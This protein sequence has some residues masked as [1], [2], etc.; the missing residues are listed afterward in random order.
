MLIRPLLRTSKRLL[1]SAP[2][3]S[4]A[5]TELLAILDSRSSPAPKSS[6]DPT[7]TTG[8]F[9]HSRLR[10]PADFPAVARWTGQ[11][12]AGIVEGICRDFDT[13]YTP[14]TANHAP[15]FQEQTRDPLLASLDIRQQLFTIVARLDKVSDL[16]CGVIDLA[17]LVKNVHP[18]QEW[19]EASEVAH[20]ELHNYMNVLNTHVGLHRALKR[21]I[22]SIPFPSSDTAD[23]ELF[24]TY[25]VA[26]QF[27]RDF[28]KS[29]IHLPPHQR[30]LFVQ[31]SDTISFLGQDIME[32]PYR[33]RS[34]QVEL[35]LGNGGKKMRLRRDGSQIHGL[36]YGDDERVRKAA[37][38]AVHKAEPEDL[39]T[40]EEML[41]KRCEVARLV[42]YENWAELTL[43]DKMA[44]TPVNVSS[45]LDAISTSILPQAKSELSILQRLKQS[46]QHLSSPP[47]VY[48]WDRD[49]LT[50]LFL[51]AT[52]SPKD[53]NIEEELSAYLS[54]GTVFR[55]LSHLFQS[56][57]GLRFELQSPLLGETWDPSVLKLSMLDDKDEKVGTV[58]LDLFWREGKNSAPAHYTVTCSRRTDLDLSSGSAVEAED[59]GGLNVEHVKKKGEEGTYQLPVVVLVCGFGRS[60]REGKNVV[61]L[62]WGEVETLF[63]EMGHAIHSMIGQTPYHNSSGTRVATDFVELPSIL[64]EHFLSSPLILSLFTHFSNQSPLPLPKLQTY[65]KQHR[66]FPALEDTWQITLADLDL[67]YHSSLPLSPSFDSTSTFSRVQNSR[68]PI[69]H[70]AGTHHQTQFSHLVGYG[71]TYYSYIFDRAIASRLFHKIFDNSP[72]DRESG[73]WFKEKLLRWGSARDPWK[74]VADALGP[75]EEAERVRSGDEKAMEEVGRWGVELAKANSVQR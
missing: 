46:T 71:A 64:M 49:Y 37:Y 25:T 6:I 38:L 39:E 29:G 50:N 62:K 44:K 67:E 21:I 12:V 3:F 4:A 60:K 30:E 54:L 74:L 58:Y 55:A 75:G 26:L 48:P 33:R 34:A 32:I 17:E 72:L 7:R 28:E 24:N 61:L 5:D 23:P 14:S 66:T 15:R 47:P 13:L 65:K 9:G 40:L 70:A 56:I 53:A 2:R 1:H 43:H 69:P 42:G 16:L 68:Y 11:R 18:S 63:H 19:V 57:Y 22:S 27:L 35:D 45:F 52:T 51:A 31:E 8:L 59:E 41:R 36:R 10:T 73:E 20:A